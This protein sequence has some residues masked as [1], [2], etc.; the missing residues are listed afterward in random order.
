MPIRILSDFDG[1]WT[2]PVHEAELV[3]A[4]VVQQA[5][6][7]VSLP[8]EEVRSEFAGFSAATLAAPE[9]YGWAPD[10][11]ITAY[12]DEDP[13]CVANGVASYLETA[14]GDRERFFAAAIR[15]AGF[16]RLTEFADR[17]FLDATA[18]YRV[19]HPPALVPGARAALT[20]LHEAGVH[21]VVVS[22]SESAKLIDWFQ[23][24]GIDAGESEESELQVCGNARK[25]HLGESDASL[26]VGGR[27][28]RVD[29]PAYREAITRIRPDLVIGDVFSLDLALPHAMRAAGEAGAPRMLV[30]HGHDHTPPWIAD[31]HAD[32]ALDAIVRGVDELLDLS[33]ALHTV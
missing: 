32:G 8:I 20:A 33:L 31:T 18:R 22:N 10:G 26:T 19:E 27:Q 4:E 2:D 17:C 21:V 25:F 5:S 30:L 11:R 24:S 23:A 13:F 1:V 28:I 29:R 7:L 9:R 12:V 3:F 14:T 15:E 6:A 16:G